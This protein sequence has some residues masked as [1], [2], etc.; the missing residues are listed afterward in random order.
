MS[1]FSS[2]INYHITGVE[3]ALKAAIDLICFMVE[4]PDRVH[5]SS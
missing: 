1:D 3:A 5:E 4:Y 2:R